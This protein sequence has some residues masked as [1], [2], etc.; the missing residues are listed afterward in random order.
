MMALKSAVE[1][2]TT[3]FILQNFRS[4]R[5]FLHVIFYTNFTTQIILHNVCSL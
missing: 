5:D 4:A 1:N 3:H 2:F